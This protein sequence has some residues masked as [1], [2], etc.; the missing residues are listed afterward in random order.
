MGGARDTQNPARMR[1]QGGVEG[2]RSHGVVDLMDSTQGTTDR[3]AATDDGD[4]GGD[5]ES[6]SPR[7]TG[8]TGDQGGTGEPED[9][10]EGGGTKGGPRGRAEPDGAKGTGR[11]MSD[12][13]GAGGTREPDGAIW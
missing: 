13:G 1:P 9:R 5:N 6:K 3:D 7:K 12:Q 8:G 2:R 11:T 4:Q 10:G